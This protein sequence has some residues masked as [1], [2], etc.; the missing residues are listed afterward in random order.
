MKAE[1][2]SQTQ[3]IDLLSTG[4][5][6]T[7]D[8]AADASPATRRVLDTMTRSGIPY[9]LKLLA[10]AARSPE[11]IAEACKCDLDFIVQS[12]VFRGKTTKKP[13]LL[14]HSAVSKISDK[15]LGF[16]VGENLQRADPDFILRLTGYPI[17]T[18][19]PLAHL[20]RIAVMLDGSLMRFARVWCPAGAANAV[21]SVPTLVLARVISARIVRLEH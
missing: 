9:S 18:V 21:I 3:E 6:S 11:E 4:P 7:G 13:F 1:F 17:D 8:D 10:A 20:N 12:T 19:P 5:V 2:V 14:L 15:H 16:I